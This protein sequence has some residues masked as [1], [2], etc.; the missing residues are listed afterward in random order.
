MRSNSA[1]GLGAAT[2]LDV[3]NRQFAG[4]FGTV[5]G[6]RVVAT[7][8]LE[9]LDGRFPLLGIDQ[10]R[11]RIVARGG[12]NFR[13]RSDRGH[14]QEVGRSAGLIARLALGLALPVNGVG[15]PLG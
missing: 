11:G 9:F 4:N 10:R 1:A 6:L 8:G 14:A 7:V 2:H 13:F 3:G 5:L 12:N 15:Q